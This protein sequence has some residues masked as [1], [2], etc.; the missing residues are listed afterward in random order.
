MMAPTVRNRYSYK[1]NL[2]FLISL[3]QK[4]FVNVKIGLMS[5]GGIDNGRIGNKRKITGKESVDLII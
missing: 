2:F 4:L 1:L 5:S 3:K